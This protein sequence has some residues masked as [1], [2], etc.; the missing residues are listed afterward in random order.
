MLATW[1]VHLSISR[2][3]TT[4]SSL[5][6]I[7]ELCPHKILTNSNGTNNHTYNSASL[8]WAHIRPTASPGWAMDWTTFRLTADLKA[9][10]FRF[11]DNWET[12]W[13]QGNR[14]DKEIVGQLKRL[15][16]YTTMFL[17]V[18]KNFST[19]T[20]SKH[21][22]L[23]HTFRM[24]LSSHYTNNFYWKLNQM[25]CHLHNWGQLLSISNN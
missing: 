2:T 7:Q 9:S 25:G 3:K 11:W 13:K 17:Y 10:R 16:I 12:T 19:G 24:K 4:Q 22:S 18:T 6:L 1:S 23:C 15:S 20:D 21:Y 5:I 8:T 14:K